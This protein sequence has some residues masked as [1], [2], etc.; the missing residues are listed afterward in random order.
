MAVADGGLGDLLFIVFIVVAEDRRHADVIS[1]LVLCFG[2]YRC[3]T[4]DNR[5]TVCIVK[6]SVWPAR[7]YFCN[8]IRFGENR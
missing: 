3:I 1:C 7:L 6:Y 8:N 5:I 4:D 2:L